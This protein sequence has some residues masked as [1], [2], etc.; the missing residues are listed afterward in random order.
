VSDIFDPIDALA[1]TTFELWNVV[2]RGDQTPRERAVYQWMKEMPIGALVMEQSTYYNRAKRK[3]A[4]GILDS[5]ETRVVCEHEHKHPSLERCDE[6]CDDNRWSEHYIW[7]RTFDGERHRWHNAEFL[8][9][10]ATIEDHEAIRALVG[11]LQH[12]ADE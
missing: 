3:H 7:L 12:K 8:R 5:R 2:I 1:H 11:F 6:C 10:P 4:I 9:I